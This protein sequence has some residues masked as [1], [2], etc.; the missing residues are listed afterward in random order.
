MMF[1][2]FAIF[3]FI[4]CMVVSLFIARI[5][6][7]SIRES[8][9]GINIYP[10]NCPKCSEN[11]PRFRSPKSFRELMWGGWNCPK[12]GCR[13]NQW[14]K[15]ILSDEKGGTK[16]L[17]QTMLPQISSFDEKGKTPVERMFEDE[18]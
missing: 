8:K 13:M 5:A 15:E 12:C 3:V 18:K 6:V 2:I 17:G 7:G 1:L 9:W 16:Q 4:L 11:M 14:G 10:V